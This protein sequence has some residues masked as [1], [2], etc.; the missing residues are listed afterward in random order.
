MVTV[1]EVGRSSPRIIR[2]V[3]DFPSLLRILW[4]LTSGTRQS[5]TEMNVPIR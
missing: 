4:H 1:P 3:I 2:M 5:L